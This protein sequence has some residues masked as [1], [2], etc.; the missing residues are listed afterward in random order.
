MKSTAGASLRHV[1]SEAAALPHAPGDMS[2]NYAGKR[3]EDYV[4]PM[5]RPCQFDPS[6]LVIGGPEQR[7]LFVDLLAKAQRRVIVHS[8]FLNPSR[9]QALLDP[10]C[11]ACERGVTFDLLWGAERDDDTEERN[12]NAASEI[13]RI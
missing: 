3:K 5:L 1:I 13:A 4:E 2:W 11:A 6:D 12:S 8:T 7:V 10:I 9:F